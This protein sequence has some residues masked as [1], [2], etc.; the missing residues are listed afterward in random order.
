MFP[1]AGSSKKPM[2]TVLPCA[3]VETPDSISTPLLVTPA[4]GAGKL[5]ASFVTG[6][7]GVTLAVSLVVILRYANND[8]AFFVFAMGDGVAVDALAYRLLANA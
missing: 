4:T 3:P 2:A 7:L 8:R 5:V 1:A 6:I